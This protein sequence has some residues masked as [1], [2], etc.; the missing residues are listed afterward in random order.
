MNRHVL[1]A[2][3]TG[4]ALAFV[5][6]ATRA[7]GI[8]VTDNLPDSGVVVNSQEGRFSATMPEGYTSPAESTEPVATSVGTIDMKFYVSTKGNSNAAMIAYSDYPE[9]ARY[10]DPS[11]LLQGACDGAMQNMKAKAL[12]QETLLIDG[13][14]GRSVYFKGKDAKRGLRG[15]VVYFLVKT[16]LYQILFLTTDGSENVDS[17]AIK[18]FFNSFRLLS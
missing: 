18:A 13:N 16:R 10:R 6:P 1:I 12:R 14:P 5:T 11:A 7:S 9:S 2:L 4:F 15:R 3:L 8:G 17:P